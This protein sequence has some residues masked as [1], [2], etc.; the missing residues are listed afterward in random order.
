MHESLQEWARQHGW[1]YLADGTTGGSGAWVN[2]LPGSYVGTV[3]ERRVTQE[4][5][6]IV[7]GREV[8]IADFSCTTVTK[9]SRGRTAETTNLAVAVITLSGHH[10]DLRVHH[11]A[12]GGFGA[13]ISGMLGL[14][15]ANAYTSGNKD[16]D[17]HYLVEEIDV[18]YGDAAR[19]LTPDVIAACLRDKLPGWQVQGDQLIIA[20]HDRPL[21]PATVD[22]LIE[23]ST[24]LAALLD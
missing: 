10:A 21:K 17:H 8:V 20:W 14:N 5:T 23:Q 19:M 6:G 22:T 4:A 11:R 2:R 16:F 15:A 3:T 13:K 7:D 9:G 18:A 24:A 12:L 1:T